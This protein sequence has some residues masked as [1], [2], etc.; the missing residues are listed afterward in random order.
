[1]DPNPVIPFA[2][3]EQPELITTGSDLVV[4]SPGV[5]AWHPSAQAVATNG[6]INA[7]TSLENHLINSG[8]LV[9]STTVESLAPGAALPPALFPP[10]FVN[11]FS[12]QSIPPLVQDTPNVQAEIKQAVLPDQLTFPA[13]PLPLV[14]PV[15]Q[16]APS[17]QDMPLGFM[18]KEALQLFR[19][20]CMIKLFFQF[21]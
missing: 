8:L 9:T 18:D 5:P 21:P 19:T 6:M 2:D 13:F 14:P 11:P 17:G 15:V 10:V 4:H 7:L 12:T 3:W 16:D 20:Q 1:M